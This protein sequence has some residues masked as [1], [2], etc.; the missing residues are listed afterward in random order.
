MP[1]VK[2]LLGKEPKAAI[3]YLYQKK[4]LAS[5]VF[6]KELHDSALALSLIHI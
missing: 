1:Q 6:N 4:L 3:E 5:K 2:F